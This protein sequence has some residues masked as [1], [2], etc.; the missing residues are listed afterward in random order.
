MLCIPL[1]VFYHMSWSLCACGNAYCFMKMLLF[2]WSNLAKCLHMILHNAR[3]M[4]NVLFLW[5]NLA[6]CLYMILNNAMM[7]INDYDDQWTMYLI[8]VSFFDC[9]YWDGIKFAM[10]GLVGA[11]VLAMS[12]LM[13]FGLAA[14]AP[15]C[16]S[17]CYGWLSI[18]PGEFCVDFPGWLHLLCTLI[19]HYV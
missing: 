8:G 3:M 17:V 18:K 16:I 19:G 7:M 5:S 6:K 4:I 9:A 14:P 13:W 11:C 1:L 12:L 10:V 15:K 2:L